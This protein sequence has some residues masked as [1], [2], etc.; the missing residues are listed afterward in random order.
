MATI[1]ARQTLGNNLILLIDTTPIDGVGLDSELGSFAIAQDGTGTFYKYGATDSDWIDSSPLN[2][3]VLYTIELVNAFTADLYAPFN[4]YIDSYVQIVGTAN[5]TIRVNGSSYT[6][7]SPINTGDLINI[8]SD[9]TSVVNL[10][11][12]QL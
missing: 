2:V 3:N 6:L 11:C 9:N 5:I 10:N 1:L 7:G 12:I 8:S 4:L